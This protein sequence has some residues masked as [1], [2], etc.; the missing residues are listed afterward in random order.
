MKF[1]W[2]G[3][4]SRAMTWGI[5]FKQKGSSRQFSPKQPV[6]SAAGGR[7]DSEQSL[8]LINDLQKRVNK[9]RRN[10]W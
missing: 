3:A 8:W 6:S 5:G 1:I 2:N 4:E 10:A 9:E 7:D